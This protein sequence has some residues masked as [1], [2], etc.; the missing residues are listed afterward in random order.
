MV[1]IVQQCKPPTWLLEKKMPGVFSKILVTAKSNPRT[2][3][4]VAAVSAACVVYS[5]WRRTSTSAIDRKQYVTNKM[6]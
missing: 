6:V 5:L 4:T 1:E 2:A 3:G